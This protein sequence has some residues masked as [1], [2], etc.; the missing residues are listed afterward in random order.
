M[1]DAA[2]IILDECEYCGRPTENGEQ[3]FATSHN[4]LVCAD[5]NETKP[6]KY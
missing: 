4:G 1:N 2:A 5:C 3:L 6:W